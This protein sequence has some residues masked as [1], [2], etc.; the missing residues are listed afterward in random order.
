MKN[1]TLF[2]L[3]AVLLQ[4][5]VSYAN[6][7]RTPLHCRMGEVT[8]V[9]GK[10]E[11]ERRSAIITP[12]S[13]T[14]IC[15]GDKLRTALG[16]VTEIKFR[17]G[18][19]VTVGK[20]SEFV[21]RDFRINTRKPNVALFELIKGAFRS[22]TGTITK[23][24]NRFEVTTRAATIGIRGTEFWGGYGLTPDGAFDVVMLEGRGVYVK[25]AR[26]QVEL[27]QVGLGT[28]IKEGEAP[29]VPKKWGEEKLKRALET[30]APDTMARN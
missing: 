13:G 14:K 8:W 2:L 29:T 3:S 23:R 30:L 10:V 28:T 5:G 6:T 1:Y 15:R 21:I 7:N 26:G 18:T 27:D 24:R 12:V 25:N 16:A 4:A 17:D 19:K 11:L 9:S 22:V 20:D